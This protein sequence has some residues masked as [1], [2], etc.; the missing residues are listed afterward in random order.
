[1]NVMRCPTC[2]LNMDLTSVAFTGVFSGGLG[3][4]L[5]KKSKKR[6]SKHEK[7]TLRAM[8]KPCPTCKILLSY[9]TY[10]RT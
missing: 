1:M 6:L 8:S 9:N 4:L 3:L 10:N 5:I 2:E 7:E